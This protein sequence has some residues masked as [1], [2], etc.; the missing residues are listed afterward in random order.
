MEKNPAAFP[1]TRSDL[2]GPHRTTFVRAD[3][4]SFKEVVQMLTG[5]DASC[6]GGRRREVAASKLYER[7]NALRGELKVSTAR[8][9]HWVGSPGGVAAATEALSPSVLD[10]LSLT[11]SPVSPL[12]FGSAA[13]A[14]NGG[15]LDMEAEEKAIREKG[16]YLHP[17]PANTPRESELRLLP[18]FPVTSPRADYA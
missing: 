9:G 12:A 15:D 11:L 18:L 10:F 8:P 5:S 16:F 2:S 13:A 17:S 1:T 3:S 6:G 14:A 7:R 4:A